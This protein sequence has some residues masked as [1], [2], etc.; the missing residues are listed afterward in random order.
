MK[1]SGLNWISNYVW[2]IAD[3]NVPRQTGGQACY[4]TD[5]DIMVR[6]GFRWGLTR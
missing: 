2:E 3:Y 4:S 6:H 5:L 1:Q